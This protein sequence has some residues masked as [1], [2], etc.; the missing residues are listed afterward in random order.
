MRSP[1]GHAFS[2]D[3]LNAYLVNHRSGVGHREVLTTWGQAAEAFLAYASLSSDEAWRDQRFPWLS[4]S[5][6]A[7]YLVQSRIV[8]WWVHGEDIRAD[9]GLGPQIQHWPIYLTVDSVCACCRG[10]SGEAGIDLQGRAC[11]SN[12][13]APARAHGIGGWGPARRHPPDKRPDAR[14]Q[15]RRSAVR[16]RG[17]AAMRP[18]DVLDS[19]IVVLGGDAD[20]AELVLRHIR[21]YA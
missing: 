18:D 2:V 21:A 6:A 9:T 10:R 19:G 17:G 1:I 7:R 15:G 3:G 11:R 20:I 8:E 14:I 16:A 5:I 4:G 12:S 13:R